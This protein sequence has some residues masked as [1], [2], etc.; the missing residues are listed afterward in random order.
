MDISDKN[1]STNSGSS[2]QINK[3]S[4]QLPKKA[5]SHEERL[6]LAA[7]LDRELD[8]FIESLPRRKYQDGWPEDRWEE[9]STDL[10]FQKNLS[11]TI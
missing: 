10:L 4:T 9:V 11:P 7:K 6:Q 1:D 8:E 5:M 2:N 3:D